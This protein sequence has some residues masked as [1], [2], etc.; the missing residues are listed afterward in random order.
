[1]LTESVPDSAPAEKMAGAPFISM[2]PLVW[3]EFLKTRHATSEV[4]RL[5]I[6][7]MTYADV[8]TG[9]CWPQLR[10]LASVMNMRVE[11]VSAC[12]DRL[13]DLGIM[14][15]I[16]RNQR[17]P[18]T[19]RVL[20]NVYALSPYLFALRKPATLS[21]HHDHRGRARESLIQNLGKIW[22]ITN[23]N[24]QSGTNN[25][26]PTIRDNKHSQNTPGFETRLPADPADLTDPVYLRESHDSTS[27][28]QKDRID[29]TAQH[30]Q[31]TGQTDQTKPAPTGA[32]PTP[33]YPPLPHEE[34]VSLALYQ[35]RLSDPEDERVAEYIHR[36]ALVNTSL[37]WIR[38]YVKAYG[39][40]LALSVHAAI[41]KNFER[42]TP[43]RSPA[44]V[45]IGLMRRRSIEMTAPNE[46]SSPTRFVSGEL[47]DY[48]E[49]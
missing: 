33:P 44:A 38:Y 45:W 6:T 20:P 16:R 35:D 9:V 23:K 25:Q 11:D 48:I 7:L 19:G 30:E 28:R 2:Y 22:I 4:L 49:R 40:K 24:K 41:E 37:P 31:P 5:T 29:K 8:E 26:E 46:A 12:M 36:A 21:L 43:M 27:E 32:T 47:A 34:T 14:T 17:D 3:R 10:E 39:R 1:M 15:Y 42:K 18:V 13:E